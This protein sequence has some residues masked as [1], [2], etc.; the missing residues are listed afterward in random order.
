VT[1]PVR[2]VD[3][4]TGE[5]REERV[6]GG[7]AL[8]FLYG[9]RLGGLLRE[10]IAVRP[11]FS[12]IYGG[13]MDRPATPERIRAF[14]D[15]AGIALAE[16]EHPL[17][18]YRT[19]NDLFCRRLKP[20]CRPVDRDP[21]HLVFPAD[22]R[23]LAFP[24]LAGGTLPLPVKGASVTVADLLG[25]AD[26]ARAY[27]GGSAVVVR[28]APGDYHRYHFPDGG[29]PSTPRRLGRRLHTVTPLSLGRGI[30]VFSL[31]RREVTILRSDGFGD[32]AIVEVGALAVG[33]IVQTHAPERRVE[34]GDE[35]GYFAFGGS[36][37]VLVA[38]PARL[39]LDR[40]LVLNTGR[41]LE[42]KVKW[43][44]RLGRRP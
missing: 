13:R 7:R 36:T 38:A 41:G 14:A 5:V 21:A 39:E 42:T 25:D 44:T 27:A 30:P 31:N 23:A 20:G 11:L 2:H 19:V 6:F 3:R 29:V 17:E 32:L 12:R 37:I 26:L 15:E 16:A 8:R 10:L 24:T 18:R 33:T 9:T 35:K 43:G 22:G 1:P 28:L 34:R 4:E 40:D